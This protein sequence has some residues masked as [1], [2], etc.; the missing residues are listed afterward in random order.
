MHPS[1]QRYLAGGAVRCFIDQLLDHLTDNNAHSLER[2]RQEIYDFMF[3]RKLAVRWED[4]CETAVHRLD[5]R[6]ALSQEKVCA[7]FASCAY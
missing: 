6:I 3:L 5:E 7:R 1:R 4:D 2:K